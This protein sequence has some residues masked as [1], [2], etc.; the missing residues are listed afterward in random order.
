MTQQQAIRD[1]VAKDYAD[2]VSTPSSSGCCA[3]GSREQKGVA[4]K[5]VGYTKDELSA[6]PDEA[7]INS[8]G[9]G[10]PTAFTN[11]TEG[12]VV[13]D[14]GSGAGIDILLAARKVGPTGTVIGIDMTD[15]MI[16]KANENIASSGFDNVEVRKG[17]IEDMPVESGTVD[18][19]ISNCVITPVAPS[20]MPLSA[21]SRL[22]S[23]TL[24]PSAA[25]P[26]LPPPP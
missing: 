15:E 14:L 12:D 16:A 20:P 5:S 9:C 22:P 17:L 10:N 26:L 7:V 19:V 24:S 13:L 2:A 6:L 4:V 3:P 8:F 21:V 11:V 18:W 23:S 25:T 1:R